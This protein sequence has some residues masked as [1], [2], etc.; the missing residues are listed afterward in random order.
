MKSYDGTTL[1][2]ASNQDMLRLPWLLK[3][4]PERLLLRGSVSLNLTQ[5]IQNPYLLLARD[6]FFVLYGINPLDRKIAR[7]RVVNIGRVNV[8]QYT[9]SQY[10]RW[11]DW[12][13]RVQ[14]LIP[15]SRE[16]DERGAATK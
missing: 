2:V 5:L 10:P 8:F 11:G 1:K 13:A 3:K 14:L 9:S 6:D 7:A 12:V 4:R 15:L 16:L